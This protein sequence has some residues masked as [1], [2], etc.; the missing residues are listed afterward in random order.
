MVGIGAEIRAGS[1]DRICF[2]NIEAR[3]VVKADWVFSQLLPDNSQSAPRI[4]ED[5]PMSVSITQYHSVSLSIDSFD[6]RVNRDIDWHIICANLF[7]TW[8]RC[9]FHIP[10]NHLCTNS[11]HTARAKVKEGSTYIELAAH[12]RMNPYLGRF[13][14]L[15]HKP[16]ENGNFCASAK[17]DSRLPWRAWEARTA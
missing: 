13:M 12:N 3:T 14:L 9:E 8:A 16:K 17:G 15:K 6:A 4:T 2:S 5:H 11:H 1:M 10:V 7:Y